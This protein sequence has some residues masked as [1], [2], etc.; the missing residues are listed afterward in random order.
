MNKV[1]WLTGICVKV[2]SFLRIEEGGTCVA[3]KVMT[4]HRTVY[5]FTT[6][7]RNI[8]LRTLER[9]DGVSRKRDRKHYQMKRKDKLA[10]SA[11]SNQVNRLLSLNMRGHPRPGQ[12]PHAKFL[13]TLRRRAEVAVFQ[14]GLMRSLSCRVHSCPD[15]T[16]IRFQQ[17]LIFPCD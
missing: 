1:S 10:K 11:V 2:A 13:P 3:L 14:V 5:V 6:I 4:S 17:P 7:F 8:L 9:T 15:R 12:C 16:I